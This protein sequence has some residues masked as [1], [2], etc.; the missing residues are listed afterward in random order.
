MH[1]CCFH[2]VRKG[3]IHRMISQLT[4]SFF[5]MWTAVNTLAVK[6]H[7][8]LNPILQ[9]R[10]TEKGFKKAENSE[11][12][13]AL[14]LFLITLEHTKSSSSKT[15]CYSLV[16][17]DLVLSLSKFS[18]RALAASPYICSYIL[19]THTHIH[20]CWA[21]TC[22]RVCVCAHMC[23]CVC[24]CVCICACMHVSVHVCMHV[25]ATYLIQ[26]KWKSCWDGQPY[27]DCTFPLIGRAAVFWG[28]VPTS[29]VWKRCKGWPQA[30]PETWQTR[31]IRD[32]LPRWF[33][34]V[35]GA[36]WCLLS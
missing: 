35:G 8:I 18:L 26:E 16:Q 28:T 19:N 32:N 12:N 31:H 20:L 4:F 22:A 11:Q 10:F 14:L 25:C 2:S 7:N 29:L 36:D 9:S 3:R 21:F 34:G 1:T 15:E 17:L 5:K 24:V 27:F 23:V 6:A 13:V 33:F 30:S